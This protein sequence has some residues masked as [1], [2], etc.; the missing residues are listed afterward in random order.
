MQRLRRYWG[1]VR[2]TTKM[3]LGFVLLV[4]L[5]G[6]GVF[7]SYTA[8]QAILSSNQ[9]IVDSIEIQRLGNGVR[10][11][12]ETLRHQRHD[13]FFSTRVNDAD[14]AYNE[15]AL[16]AST[17]IADIIRDGVNLARLTVLP[18]ASPRL[19]EQN[20]AIQNYLS[21]V[22]RYVTLFQETTDLEMRLA[23]KNNGLKVSA[24]ACTQALRAL[25]NQPGAPAELKTSFFEMLIVAEHYYTTRQNAA[26]SQILDSVDSLRE[27]TRISPLEAARKDEILKQLAEYE[28]VLHQI[29][30]IDQQ[31]D[32]N[33]AELDRRETLVENQLLELMVAVD[34]QVSTAKTDIGQTRTVM[35]SVLV[36][37]LAFVVVMTLLIGLLLHY[38]VTRNIVRLTRVAAQLQASQLDARAQVDSSDELGQLA[39]TFNQMAETLAQT[40]LQLEI[41][42]ETSMALAHG[43]EIDKKLVTAVDAAVSLSKAHY[44]WVGLVDGS[45]LRLVYH[46]GAGHSLEQAAPIPLND[47]WLAQVVQGRQAR[48]VQ[49]LPDNLPASPLEAAARQWVAPLYAGERLV[50]VWGL[51]MPA[52]EKI[53]SDTLKFLN[54]LASN[55]AVAIQNAHTHEELQ[56]LAVQDTLTGL[57]NRRGLFFHG[58]REVSRVVRQKSSLCAVFVDVDHFK[59]FNDRYSYE[60]G[61][62]VLKTVASLLLASTR[63]VDLAARY[64]G[65]EFIILFPDVR[66]DE[67]TL[68]AERL[69]KAI[70]NFRLFNQGVSLSITASLGVA[71]LA[72]P[73]EISQLKAEDEEKLLT[74]LIERAASML[75]KA[76]ASGRNC[77]VVQEC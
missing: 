58:L 39:S 59:Q 67:T 77:V 36:G 32:T 62:Q 16:P 57:Y 42:H 31:V 38:A 41:L 56:R 6:L 28:R 24:D 63:R 46:S 74:A 34:Q 70:E 30:L 18:E 68:I 29:L 72:I 1:S 73:P 11:K 64:G 33:L 12:W 69:R 49:V 20:P 27:N 76:K 52:P 51:G 23:S 61:D 3:V 65:E 9:V 4:L 50:G 53:S 71:T 22:Q 10:R 37:T 26:P 35:V 7:T 55:T 44:G 14:R 13:F 47:G 60:V 21:E 40:I 48:L 75:H 25:F 8:M 43:F 66:L 5:G 2:I 15:H 54:L 19:R 17:V 45:Q